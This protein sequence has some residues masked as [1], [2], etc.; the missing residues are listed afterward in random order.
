[1]AHKAPVKS[2]KIIFHRANLNGIIFSRDNQGWDIG[3]VCIGAIRV[4]I[5]I[6]MVATNRAQS[7]YGGQNSVIG[8]HLGGSLAGGQ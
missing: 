4:N 8:N 5:S 3:L 7:P 6:K 1:M 2:P